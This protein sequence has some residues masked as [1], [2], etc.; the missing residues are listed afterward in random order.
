MDKTPFSS[1]CEL[2]SA[3]WFFYRDDEDAPDGWQEFF[4]WA[5][6]GL[7]LAYVVS[8]NL[9][10]ITDE[11]TE[12]IKETWEYLCEMISV[13]PTAQYNTIQDMFDAAGDDE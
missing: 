7:P 12:I 13:D 4:R 10:N 8:E 3:L 6:V 2:L 5:D 1:K 9:A 11:G